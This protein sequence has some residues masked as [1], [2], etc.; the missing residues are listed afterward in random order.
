MAQDLKELPRKW[1][2]RQYNKFNEQSPR[3]ETKADREINMQKHKQ[4]AEVKSWQVDGPDFQFCPE[5]IG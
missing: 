2:K 4:K 1:K 5:Y 3:E